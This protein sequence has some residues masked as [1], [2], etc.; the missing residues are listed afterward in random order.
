M[1]T[2]LVTGGNSGIGKETAKGLVQAGFRVFIASRN[3][4]KSQHVIDEISSEF[5]GAQ[6]AAIELDL[7]DL[8]QVKKFAIAFQARVPVL[9]VLILNA[10]IF[11][12]R[13]VKTQQGFESQMGVNHLGHFLLTKLL[14]KTVL[15]APQGRIIAVSSIAHWL[16]SAK[17]QK[18]YG[19][20]FHNP[21][22]TY[23]QSKLANLLFIK[24]L[25][26]NLATTTVLVNAVHP[27]V[28]DTEIMN[29]I[30]S[31]LRGSISKLFSSPKVGAESSIFL[32]TTPDLSWRGELVASCKPVSCS[33]V[34]TKQAA[35]SLWQDSEKLIAP[36]IKDLDC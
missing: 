15:A 30:P 6:I 33:P 26:E 29:D 7:A 16:S 27:G 25:A 13:A 35:K 3:L 14:L 5:P 22:S 23:A 9:D 21:V 36:Y 24:Q 4:E 19:G 2:A 11:S 20:R 10:G 12:L 32:A 34:V 17:I 1:K 31:W 18:F 8:E 28:V